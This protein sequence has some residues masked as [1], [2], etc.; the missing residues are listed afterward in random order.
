M[1]PCVCGWLGD[2]SDQC[3]CTP[4]IID[5]Y[6]ARVSGPLLDRIDLHVEVPRVA[7]ASLGEEGTDGEPS[8]TIRARV[9]AAR[10]RQRTRLARLGVAVNAHVPGREVRRVCRID[11]R[12]RRLLEAASERLG[13]SARAYTRILRVAQT[14]ADLAGEELTTSHLAEAIQYR[15]L[16]RRPGS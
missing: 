13:L 12:G 11:A 16:D 10:A 6:R 14:I 7:V 1:N 15:S 9:L 8:A 2:P 3:R 4:P 5:R